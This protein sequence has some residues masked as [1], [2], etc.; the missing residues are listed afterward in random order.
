MALEYLAQ[1]GN[2]T[3]LNLGTGRGHS[4][5]EVLRVVEEVTGRNLRKRLRPRR[6]GDPP[7]LVAD[8]SRAWQLLHWK[9]SRTLREMVASAWSWMQSSRQEQKYDEYR[10]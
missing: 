4:N 8:P 10:S 5:L 2:S 6:P 1:D 7:V 3:E 9:A